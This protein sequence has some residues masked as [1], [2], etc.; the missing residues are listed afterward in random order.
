[1]NINNIYKMQTVSQINAVRGG[2]NGR[3]LEIKKAL[4]ARPGGRACSDEFAV[5]NQLSMPFCP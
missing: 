2:A 3:P 4:R 1:M 5:K